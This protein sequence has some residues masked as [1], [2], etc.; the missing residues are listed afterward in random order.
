MLKF[1]INIP[2]VNTFSFAPQI[3]GLLFAKGLKIQDKS[4]RKVNTLVM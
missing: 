4:V 3:L 2:S 1:L